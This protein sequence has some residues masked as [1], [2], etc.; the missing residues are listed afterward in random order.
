MKDSIKA[1]FTF[2]R[3][4]K[5]GTIILLAII[6]FLIII[7]NITPLLFSN[8]N[9]INYKQYKSEIE[10]FK[11]SLEASSP[12]AVNNKT[13][14]YNTSTRNTSRPEIKKSFS[15]PPVQQKN[16]SY[17]NKKETPATSIIELNTADSNLLQNIS[18][19]GPVFSA[20][21]IKYRDLLG[22]YT[23][24]KQ[25]KEVYG[26]NDTIYN[27]IKNY[28]KLDTTHVKKISVNDVPFKQLLKHPYIDYYQTKAIFNYKSVNGPIKK[29][30]EIITNKLVDTNNYNKLKPY[31]TVK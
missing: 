30:N 11:H 1:L 8:R 4:E 20:R 21:I 29:V 3:K 17:I 19:I 9:N 14:N 7:L 2:S 16:T 24:L 10:T 23:S 15:H 28:L 13:K 18:G 25:L 12:V 5:N 6:L 26:I 31:L 22:G 27:K